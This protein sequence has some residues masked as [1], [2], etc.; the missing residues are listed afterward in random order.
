MELNEILQEMKDE[1]AGCVGIKIYFVDKN[2]YCIKFVD[3]EK[4][5]K[6]TQKG[7]TSNDMDKGGR[8]R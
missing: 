1:V 3:N 8:N 6:R 7:R 4:V 2:N 5:I